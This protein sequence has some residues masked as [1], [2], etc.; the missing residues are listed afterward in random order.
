MA[1]AVDHTTPLEVDTLFID[2]SGDCNDPR[3]RRVG[4]SVVN[5]EAQAPFALRY[6]W[7]G[8]LGDEVHTTPRAELFALSQALSCS[9]GPVLIYSD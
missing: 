7:C 2:G 1:A 5:I 6:G 9:S 4:W 3:L 8:G